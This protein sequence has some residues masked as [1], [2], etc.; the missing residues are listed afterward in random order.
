[1]SHLAPV[2]ECP[3][4]RERNPAGSGE[5]S[6]CG[7][8]LRPDDQTTVDGAPPGWSVVAPAASAPAG[9]TLQ[10]GSLLANRHEILQVLGEGG[11]GTV[12]KARDRELDRVVAVKVIRPELAGQPAILQRFKQELILARQIT[13]KNVIRIFDLGID[14]NVKF[15]TMEFIEGRDLAEVMRERKLTPQESLDIVRQTCRA[16]R[17]AHAEGVI[18]RDLKP[19]NILVDGSGKVSVMDFGLARSLA[20]QGLTQTGAMMGTPAYMSPEQAQGRTA[21]ARSDLYALGIIFYELLTGSVPFQAETILASLLKRT[22]GKP[23]PAHEADSTVPEAFSKVADKCL[24]V[25]PPARYQS[26]EELLR[27]LDALAGDSPAA[28]ESLAA[29]APA[30][31]SRAVHLWEWVAA[32]LGVL[33]LLMLV[34]GPASR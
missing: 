1:M 29:P 21:D 7:A 13:D 8:L 2:R 31:S 24:E 9:G 18:H 12:Y 20:L 28:A 5:C 25:D 11:M 30:R 6:R 34:A 17:A 23:R 14:G 3:R 27:E 10:P 33:L 19:Q 15:I 32:T 16:L 4:C 22:Q 26:A